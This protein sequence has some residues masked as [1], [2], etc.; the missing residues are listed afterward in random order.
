MIIIEPILSI[1]VFIMKFSN[2]KFIIL[3]F[4]VDDILIVGY[5]ARKI[6]ML[7]REFSKSFAMKAEGLA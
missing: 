6:E 7:K 3:L 1:V 4:Y 5:N 2:N